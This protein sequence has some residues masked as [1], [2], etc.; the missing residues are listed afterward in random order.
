MQLLLTGATGADPAI[1]RITLLTRRAIPEWTVLPESAA[2]KTA[3]ILHDDLTSYPPELAR[4]LAVHDACIWALGR[5]ALGVGEQEY[6]TFT[7][8][9]LIAAVHA[10]Q[11]ARVGEGRQA[12]SPFRFVY[13]S[14]EGA[15]PTGKTTQMWARVKGRTESELIELCKSSPGM[16]AHVYRPGYFFPSKRYP[17]DRKNQRPASARAMDWAITPIMSCFLPSLLTPID[18]LA[19]FTIEVAK[20]RWPDEDLF[21]NKRM[22]ELVKDI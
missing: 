17:E 19:R 16:K 20:G 5:S 12:E 22:R 18:D 13:L 1:T 7:H 4:H 11:E 3:V 14:G 6:T 2:S 15:D 8:D 9:Y 10:I 21:V